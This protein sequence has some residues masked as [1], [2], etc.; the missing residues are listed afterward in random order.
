MSNIIFWSIICT[1]FAFILGGS[2][3]LVKYSINYE[4]DD[5][6]SEEV[7]SL[8]DGIKAG[9]WGFVETL[10]VV[11]LSFR[12]TGEIGWRWCWVFSPAWIS[13]LLLISV[14]ILRKVA[15]HKKS[16]VRKLP[17]AI[18]I[19]TD[20]GNNL[21]VEESRFGKIF[22]FRLTCFFDRKDRRF[23]RLNGSRYYV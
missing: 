4:Y 1:L 20:N 16:L 18:K 19:I 8:V 6:I 10:Q 3:L 12:L 21:D 5:D 15:D 11:F 22:K 23:V 17:N 2:T 7:F 14:F 9:F 13:S